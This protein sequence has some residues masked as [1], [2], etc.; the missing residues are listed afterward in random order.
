MLCFFLRHL[1]RCCCNLRRFCSVICWWFHVLGRMLLH[2][3]F[4]ITPNKTNK[5]WLEISCKEKKFSITYFIM[6]SWRF[7][8]MFMLDGLCS[9]TYW[10]IR[11]SQVLTWIPRC[12]RCR[13]WI[14][15]FRH[16]SMHWRNRSW[17]MQLRL[18]QG[19]HH[20][21]L[22]ALIPF[23]TGL[24]GDRLLVGR[25]GP[26]VLFGSSTEGVVVLNVS[27]FPKLH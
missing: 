7:G 22:W 12:M 25:L 3:C 16:R 17:N 21:C 24:K 15:H 2:C 9:S 26:G 1:V 20:T 4:D 6:M 5:R 19:I 27:S 23:V 10:T 18:Q 11:V 13:R 14:C 8:G